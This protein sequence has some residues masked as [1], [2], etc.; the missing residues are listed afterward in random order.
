MGS[1][2]S[3]ESTVLRNLVES[4]DIN[5][6][7]F[8]KLL[9]KTN[10]IV[11]GGAALHAFIGSNNQFDGDIDIWIQCCPDLSS[12]TPKEYELSKKYNELNK[13][14]ISRCELYNLFRL[15]F[16]NH[17]YRN[18]TQNICGNIEYRIS[19]MFNE[20]IYKMYEYTKKKKIQVFFTFLNNQETLKMFDLSCCAT[21]WDG[22]KFSSLEPELTRA[23]KSY[24]QPSYFLLPEKNQLSR[25]RKYSSRGFTFIERIDDASVDITK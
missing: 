21:C 23:K 15:F 9:K 13:S 11:A 16:E 25:T 20:N 6:S 3:I 24:Y 10:G 22:E 8:N 17:G 12:D 19:P 4:F 7:S 1:Y 14:C 2:P 18:T 5:F